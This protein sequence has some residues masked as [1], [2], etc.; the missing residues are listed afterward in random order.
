[1]IADSSKPNK[2]R[3]VYIIR[4]TTRKTVS[5]VERKKTILIQRVTEGDIA[6]FCND[7]ERNVVGIKAILSPTAPIPDSCVLT[8][9]LLLCV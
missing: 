2:L 3:N 1:M 7:I 8:C 6:T 5:V 9:A 4:S